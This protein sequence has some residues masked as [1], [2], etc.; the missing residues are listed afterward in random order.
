MTELIHI[1][2]TLPPVVNG[3]GDYAVVL[4]RTLR[5]RGVGSCFVVPGV[6]EA[7]VDGFPATR[8]AQREAGALAAALNDARA[9]NVVVHFAAYGYAH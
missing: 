7:A 8:L 9:M 5:Q 6:G 2:P 1:T 4:A 3:L